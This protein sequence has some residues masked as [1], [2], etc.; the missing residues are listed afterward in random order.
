M[1][2]KISFNNLKLKPDLSTTEF[3]FEGK[4]IQVLNYLDINNKY[5]LIMITLQKSEENGIYNPLKL[6]MYFHLHLIYLYTNITFTEKQK[7]DESK[8]YDILKSNGFI[9][10]FLNTIKDEEY[11][12]L[13][14]MLNET[15]NELMKYKNTAGSVIQSIIQ[16]LPKNAQI[17]SEI[18]E[19]FDKEKY[20]E[21][22]NF[23]RAANGNRSIELNNQEEVK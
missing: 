3:N 16:D 18:V 21:V 17:A 15:K 10:Q 8:I 11:N 22:I 19:S 2:N 4:E 14:E 6:E 20:Q 12:F 13:F 5:D 9:Y 23:A 7:E 1:K